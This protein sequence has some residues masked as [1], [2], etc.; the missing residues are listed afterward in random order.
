M[1][2][3]PSFAFVAVPGR[4][5]LKRSNLKSTPSLTPVPSFFGVP[6]CRVGTAFAVYTALSCYVSTVFC[7]WVCWIIYT[8]YVVVHVQVRVREVK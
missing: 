4:L 3:L 6:P 2:C 8:G 7:G 1:A 5:S